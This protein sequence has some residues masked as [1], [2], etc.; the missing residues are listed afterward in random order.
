MAGAGDRFE[1]RSW[2]VS[3]NRLIILLHEKIRAPTAD[4]ASELGKRRSG[5]NGFG[6]LSVIFDDGIKRDA[7]MKSFMRVACQIFQKELSNKW[8]GN[9]PAEGAVDLPKGFVGLQSETAERCI[10]G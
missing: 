6:Q 9:R 5:G 1:L 2:K 4:K 10:D 7:P 3:A 8:I